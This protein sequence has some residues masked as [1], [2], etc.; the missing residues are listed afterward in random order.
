MT[1]RRRRF[2]SH[3]MR[4][5]RRQ[6][7]LGGEY[8]KHYVPARHIVSCA[9]TH[10]HHIQHP[11]RLDTTAKIVSP[12]TTAGGTNT[13]TVS[14]SCKYFIKAS[15]HSST[16]PFTEDLNSSWTDLTLSGVANGCDASCEPEP[17]PEAA[18][19]SGARG[20]CVERYDEHWSRNVWIGL[21]ER[22]VKREIRSSQ[23]RLSSRSIS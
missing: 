22:V 6:R 12:L 4:R 9:G 14:P 10:D 8:R 17:E 15:F 11:P 20:F 23:A 18:A 5:W 3:G 1:T 21:V 19:A 16:C 7:T 2:I 13:L